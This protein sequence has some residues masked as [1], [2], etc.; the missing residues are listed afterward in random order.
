MDE[1]LSTIFT[2]SLRACAKSNIASVQPRTYALS[3]Y[4]YTVC[5]SLYTY[6][7]CMYILTLHVCLSNSKFIFFLYLC[8]V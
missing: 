6:T 7:T 3:L 8:T 4:A 2:L 5:M 1:N